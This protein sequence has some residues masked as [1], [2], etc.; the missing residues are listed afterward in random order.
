[1]SITTVHHDLP[2]EVSKSILK[3]M[4]GSLNATVIAYARMHLRYGPRD[5]PEVPTIDDAND[6]IAAVNEEIAR[7]GITE[8]QGFNAQMPT[9]QL[10]QH[11]MEL[12]DFFN[13]CL[14]QMQTTKNDVALTI[15][16]TVKF[17]LSRPST[18]NDDMIEALA[19]AV[20][21]DPEI[22]KA[23]QLKMVNDDA[24]DLKANAGRIVD[25]LGQY[26]NVYCWQDDSDVEIVFST[27]P[28]HVQ[29]KLVFAALRAH[30]KAKQK[31]MISLLR[32]KLDAAG[33]IKMVSAHH[34]DLV[35]YLTTFSKANRV[36]LDAYMERGGTLPL[37]EDRTIV[38]SNKAASGS[39]SVTAVPAASASASVP[40][41]T[42]VAASITQAKNNP[43]RGPRRAPAPVQ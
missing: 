11:L 33:D 38:T 21:M 42:K 20:E 9:L 37:L 1:M 39:P 35:V 18:T 14:L 31:A 8:D 2:I 7:A 10:I 12:R 29:Y 36:E 3:S 43:A 34:A 25:F 41:E 30:D 5:L 13:D 6:E 32:G 16:E 28:A 23:A 22:L 24:S 4:I 40:A 26:D 17:Q 27:L 19:A 15:A